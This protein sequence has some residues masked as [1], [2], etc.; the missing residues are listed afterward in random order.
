M[1]NNNAIQ[2]EYVVTKIIIYSKYIHNSLL[3]SIIDLL[4]S[5]RF[6]HSPHKIDGRNAPLLC[7]APKTETLSAIFTTHIFSFLL[8]RSSRLCTQTKYLT[9]Q[10]PA[11]NERLRR[12][13]RDDSRP[14][15][16]P[17]PPPPPPRRRQER[18]KAQTQRPAAGLL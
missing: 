1:V 16:K 15:I 5:L 10:H 6:A 13:A 14:T 18:R 9:V 3:H 8:L 2:L 4:L 12:G 7:V 17:P 11:T